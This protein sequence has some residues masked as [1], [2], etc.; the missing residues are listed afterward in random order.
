M[1]RVEARCTFLAGVSASLFA[2]ALTGLTRQ[3][4]SAH[5]LLAIAALAVAMALFFRAATLSG[6]AADSR[7][8]VGIAHGRND[9]EWASGVPT[10]MIAGCLLA[11]VGLIALLYDSLAS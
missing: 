5:R 1:T 2:N 9:F 4:L 7:R 8:A 11:I 6:E 10:K 3:L